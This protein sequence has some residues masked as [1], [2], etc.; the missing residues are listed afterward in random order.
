M[1]LANSPGP[2]TLCSS[3]DGGSY[4]S[5]TSC[6]ELDFTIGFPVARCTQSPCEWLAQN[7]GM[8]RLPIFVPES[9]LQYR[10]STH[11]ARPTADN[12]EE[13][14]NGPDCLHGNEGPDLADAVRPRGQNHEEP[15]ENTGDGQ[16]GLEQVGLLPCSPEQSGEK[17]DGKIEHKK[18][19]EQTH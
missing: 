4:L 16:C 8:A 5:D 6:N 15:A 1:S 14:E 9:R 13:Q 17:V 12:P 19:R 18:D 2:W 7:G 3:R 10:L 11:C